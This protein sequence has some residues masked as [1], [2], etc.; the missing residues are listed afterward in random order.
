MSAHHLHKC[1]GGDGYY[2]SHFA[3]EKTEAQS[4]EGTCLE[5]MVFQAPKSRPPKHAVNR[6]PS[7]FPLEYS[8]ESV[9][10]DT[11]G[12]RYP[13]SLKTRSNSRTHS[14]LEMMQSPPRQESPILQG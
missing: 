8:E 13:G 3:E 11:S 5:V 2:C 1:L 10:L 7:R 14:L 9:G 4:S 12:P 6:R